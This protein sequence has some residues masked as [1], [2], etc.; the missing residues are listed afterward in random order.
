MKRAI[1][2]LALALAACDGDPGAIGAAGAPGAQGSA[3][4]Q[5]PAGPP[6]PAGPQGPAGTAAAVDLAAFVRSG[7]QEPWYAE[8]REVNELNLID[9]ENP[10]EFDDLF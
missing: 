6:G 9:T 4:G 7:I 2:L 3:G 5:G 10:N 8:P 1:L